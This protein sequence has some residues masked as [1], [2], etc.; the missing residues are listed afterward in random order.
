[1]R[2]A[3]F[4]IV[5]SNDRRYARVLVASAQR[6]HP[7]WERLV[8]LVGATDASDHDEAFTTVRIE[9]LPLPH[10][11]Q[12]F[13]RYT[14]LEL[15]TAAKPWMFEHVF[16]KG[17]D[18]VIYLDPDIVIYSPLVELDEAHFITVTPH[19]TG[20]IDSDAHPSEQT[21]LQAGAHNPG[22]LAVP[23]GPELE[24]FLDR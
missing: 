4:A 6:H 23:R 2:A 20:S 17:Y 11:R 22:F 14:I 19:L 7:E 12:F 1:M 5:S 15:N 21:I 9:S 10:A 18:R 16:A 24:S 3:R 8:L 13:F